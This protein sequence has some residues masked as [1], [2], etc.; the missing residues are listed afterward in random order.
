MYLQNKNNIFDLVWGTNK[1]GSTTYGDLFHL[2]EQ[3]QSAYNFELANT[4][5]LKN[6]F[7]NAENAHKLLCKQNLVLPAFEQILKASDAFNMLDAR[8]A[9]AVTS[10]Q[11]YI[12][13]IRS[14]AHETAK[15]YKQTIDEDIENKD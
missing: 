7:E 14:M 15:I 11:K 2:N 9:I 12:L 4:D 10:R 1:F 3:Q 13:K 5:T 6:D 8:K